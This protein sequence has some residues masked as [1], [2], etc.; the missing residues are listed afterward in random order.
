VTKLGRLVKNQKIKTLEDIYLFSLAVKEYQIV[1][2]FFGYA[3]SRR[4]DEDFSSPKADESWSA[5]PIQGV[6]RG[7]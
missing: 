1:E 7:W 3:I 2:A 4:G 6:C 5:N